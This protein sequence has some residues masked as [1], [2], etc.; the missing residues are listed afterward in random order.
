MEVEQ[1]ETEFDP[2]SA[3]IDQHDGAGGGFKL[4]CGDINGQQSTTLKI[5]GKCVVVKCSQFNRLIKADLGVG[6]STPNI[7]H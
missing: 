4:K 5:L 3:C 6:V 1:Q 7:I 2:Q